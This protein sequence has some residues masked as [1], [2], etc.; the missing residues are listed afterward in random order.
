MEE[1][2]EIIPKFGIGEKFREN[3]TEEVADMVTMEIPQYIEIEYISS[4]SDWMG[5]YQY[6][7]KQVYASGRVNFETYFESHLLLNYEKFDK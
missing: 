4:Q 1:N 5:E 2:C 6:F 3:I 7:V